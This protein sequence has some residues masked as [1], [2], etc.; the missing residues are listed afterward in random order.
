MESTGKKKI[1]FSND[2][3]EEEVDYDDDNAMEIDTNL[4]NGKASTSKISADEDVDE[5]FEVSAVV[6]DD[7]I[8]KKGLLTDLFSP[9]F[10]NNPFL[11]SCS[12][13]FRSA[14]ARV[15]T[16][17]TTDTEAWQALLTEAQ[18]SFRHINASSDDDPDKSA[19]LDFIEACYGVLLQHFP[20]SSVHLVQILDI[21]YTISALPNEDSTNVRSY[22]YLQIN[23]KPR[24]VAAEMK[25]EHIFETA[26]GITNNEEIDLP[27]TNGMN[28]SS[29]DLWLIYIKKRT[30]DATRKAYPPSNRM[31][32]NPPITD[33]AK[34]LRESITQAY[35]TT[36]SIAYSIPNCHLL[37]RRYL[38]HV[39]SWSLITNVNDP[40]NPNNDMQTTDAA[41]ANEQML[42][43][44]KIYQTIIATPMPNLEDYWREYE[45]FER[46]LSDV[47]AQVLLTEHL[48]SYQ[49]ARGV[50]LERARYMNATTT[51]NTT[52]AAFGQRWAT[53]PKVENT[54]EIQAEALIL[55]KFRA[56]C[57]YER[58]NPERKSGMNKEMVRQ[59]YKEMVSAFMRHPE[60][61]HE[62]AMWEL[63]T[64]EDASTAIPK[65]AD[66]TDAANKEITKSKTSTNITNSMQVFELA[67][68]H[69]P[70]CALLTI[71]QAEVMEAYGK[72]P[73]GAMKILLHYVSHITPCALGYVTLQKMVRRHDGIEA[74]RK[75]FSLAR[76]YLNENQENESETPD[77]TTD[78]NPSITVDVNIATNAINSRNQHTM[79][80]SRT[81]IH[82]VNGRLKHNEQP[83]NKSRKKG[84]MTWHVFACHANIEHRLNA[85]P[86]VAARV[87][88]LG[89]R[90]H[91]SF[92]STPAYV[93][94]YADLLWELNETENLR[95]L[96]TRSIAACEENKSA[97]VSMPSSSTKPLWDTMLKLECT[98]GSSIDRIRKVEANRRKALYNNLD[99]DFTNDAKSQSANDYNGF[100]M[101]DYQSHKVVMET[102]TRMDGFDNASLIGNGLGRML[103]R[104]ELMGAF[105]DGTSL[106]Q[107]S[108]SSLNSSSTN[109]ANDVISSGGGGSS[110]FSFAKRVHHI[111][112]QQNIM[113]TLSSN[114]N[115]MNGSS[116][117]ST[118]TSG[119]GGP[120]T[121]FDRSR[122]ARERMQLQQQQN[123]QQSALVTNMNFPEWLRPLIS[124]LPP[125]ARFQRGAVALLQKPP[126]HLVEMALAF[127]KSTPLCERPKD[128]EN[129]L[130][131]KKLDG[132]MNGSN[133]GTK[134]ARSGS[135][136]L[137]SDDEADTNASHNL[138]KSSLGGSGYGSQFRMRQRARQSQLYEQKN[139]Q[140]EVNEGVENQQ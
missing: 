52:A 74:S 110:D 29:V 106:S 80:K 131:S 30:R 83:S 134:R 45:Q 33:A 20:Y 112:F 17:P 111:F 75:I 6:E 1:L 18:I 104:C 37:W 48:P 125:P 81:T 90:K 47:L 95:A 22:D 117:N 25:M 137:S 86:R 21:L 128:D 105:G 101:Q 98:K 77:S 122:A 50:Y 89:L 70:D 56:R 79:V 46:N 107:N 73:K 8:Q 139:S 129:G 121:L 66:K 64:A 58:T 2:K 138:I 57:A 12:D 84:K 19:K 102:L 108:V 43:L 39:R 94:Q 114:T 14:L 61:W 93:L 59:V 54:E 10:Q 51:A 65:M 49:H 109:I 97:A 27:C 32:P 123:Q 85:L 119:V 118:H 44:R 5:L 96:L 62:W 23:L 7:I 34:Y 120:T 35:K 26:M 126:P 78:V 15:R 130:N 76:K 99:V 82:S 36:L 4:C 3:E 53:P 103:D 40:N 67:R 63:L 71:S 72:N 140:T 38:T 42:L 115:N 60:V 68:K 13:R 136:Y 69:I 133:N 16:S 24:Q 132:D 55:A 9:A 100:T 113:N 135:A 127:L 91:H 11:S 124:L 87:Y 116:S 28:M 31:A 92:L 41:L 88:E